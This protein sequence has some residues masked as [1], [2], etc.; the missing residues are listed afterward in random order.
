MTIP[1]NTRVTFE[2]ERSKF[3]DVN[4]NSLKNQKLLET[5]AYNV[6]ER[7]FA[8]NYLNM[9]SK[10]SPLVTSFIPLASLGITNYVTHAWVRS[11]SAI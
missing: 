11:I 10:V 3:L 4:G 7:H 9:T 6:T 8:E 2:F 1:N 5:V